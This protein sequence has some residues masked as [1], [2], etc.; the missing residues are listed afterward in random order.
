MLDALWGPRD[1][2]IRYQFQTALAPQLKGFESAILAAYDDWFAFEHAYAKD[3]DSATVVGFAFSVVARLTISVNLLTLGHLTLSGGAFRQAQ[4]ALAA[5]F[6]MAD[7]KAPYRQQLWDGQF[8][9]SKAV[10]LFLKQAASDSKLNAAAVQGLSKARA[11]YNGY[12][13]PTLLAMADTIGLRGGGH[14]LGASFDQEKMP[15]YSKELESR[16]GFARTLPNAMDG[17]SL[18][19]QDWPQFKRTG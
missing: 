5:A 16:T 17:I 1:D 15:F 8:S 13:H 14:H 2:E 12:S 18:R 10:G 7:Y 4:E 6:V 11:F 19:M 3:Q 9:I